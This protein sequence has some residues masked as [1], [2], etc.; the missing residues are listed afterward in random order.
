MKIENFDVT[1]IDPAKFKSE[2]IQMIREKSYAKREV[3]LSSGLRSDFYVDMKQ[4]LLHSRGI[5]LVASL[6]L[7]QL[8]KF[9]GQITGVGGITMGADPLSTAVSMLSLSWNKPVHAFYIRKDPKGHGTNEW[10]EGLKNFSPGEKVFILEDVVTTGGSS[11]KAVERAE[12][13][14]L[15]VMGIFTCVDREEGGRQT[16]E[17]KGIQLLSLTTKSEIV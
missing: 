9:D 16:I 6:M 10:V 3:T 8:K 14:G 17:A 5:Y 13:A 2:L 15:K 4:T 11:L 7:N 1:K 12:M